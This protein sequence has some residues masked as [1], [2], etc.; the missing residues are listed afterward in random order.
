MNIQGR[1]TTR[2]R[3]YFSNLAQAQA[4]VR[5][6]DGHALFFYRDDKLRVL[7]GAPVCI[8][9]AFADGV[10]A[11][12]LH[13]LVLDRIEGSGTWIELR[14]ARPVRTQSEY[15]RTSRRLGCDLAVE[16]RTQDCIKTGRLLDLSEGGARIV[17]IPGLTP[18]T[19]V[20]LRLLSADR[21]TFHDL[22]FGH[23]AWAQEGELGVKF[24]PEDLIGKS[25]VTK[26]LLDTASHWR[27]VW[28]TE[29]PQSCCS[30]RGASDPETPRLSSIDAATDELAAV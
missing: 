6:V 12:L 3:Y 26:L 30:G 22:S 16:V 21:L 24:D 27:R 13:G 9:F 10:A 28:E 29:H 19:A 23:V 1:A 25:A 17:G 18:D 8:E 20:E 4:H 2:L 5:E 15:A 14:D 11:R 7:P